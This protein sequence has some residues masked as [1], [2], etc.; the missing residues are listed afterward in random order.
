MTKKLLTDE[1]TLVRFL[2]MGV[3]LEGFWKYDQMA[4]QLKG[5]YN[6]RGIKY[7]KYDFLFMFEQSSGHGKIRERSFNVHNMSVR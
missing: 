2:E 1:L 3:N 5:I 7:P 4:L 6:L